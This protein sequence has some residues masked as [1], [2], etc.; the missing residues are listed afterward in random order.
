[1]DVQL[2]NGT[3]V[4]GVPDGVTKAQLAERLKSNGMDV[5]AEW[6]SKPS[7]FA[8]KAKGAVQAGAALLTGAVAAPI[9]AV[10]GVARSLVGGNFG[11]QAG[12]RE[13]Q[14]RA[15]EVSKALTYEPRT[16]EGKEALKTISGL[17]DKSKLAGS[18]VAAPEIAAVSQATRPAV[19]FASKVVRQG[20]R[21]LR[22]LIPSKEPEM[23]GVGSATTADEAMRRARADALPAP[24]QLTKGQASRTFEQQQFERETAKNPDLGGPLRERFSQQNQKILQNFDAWVDQTGAEAGSL[25]ATGESVTQAIVDKSNKAKS[26]I[27]SAYEAARKGGD[28][29]EKVDVSPLQSYVDDHQAEAINATVLQS[30]EAKLKSLASKDGKISINDLEEIRKMTGR[31]SGKDATNAVFGKEVKGVIDGMTEGKGGDL[32]KRARAL[33]TRYGQEFEDHAVVDK[34]L[35]FKPGTK[36]RA[37]AY[38]DVFSH[39]IL[40]GSLDDVRTMRKVLQTSGPKGEQAWKELQGATLKHIRDEITNNVQIDQA[41]RNVVSPAKLNRLVNELDKDGKLDFIFGKQGAQQ[42][43][44]INGIAQDVFTSPPGSVNHS[45]TSSVLLMMLDRM[46]SKTTGIPFVGSA[47]RYVAG[48]V[49]NA[50]IRKKVQESLE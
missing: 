11:T 21:D 15:E 42:I 27:R 2:P 22:D 8:D 6:M 30:V 19:G 40:K 47:A 14:E 41:G 43:R 29:Q 36:D 50:G 37:V 38:E 33:R 48:E 32:Y 26:Q 1:M 7:S 25:R 45:N 10:S 35:S 4:K 44:D 17:F 9:G 3:I 39:S 49:K 46:A 34:L 20:A 16:E 31:L 24:I 23:V 18:V 28:M 12:V 5:P 13:G